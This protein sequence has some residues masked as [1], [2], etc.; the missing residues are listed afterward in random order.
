M[1]SMRLNAGVGGDGIAGFEAPT[2]ESNPSRRFVAWALVCT[3]GGAAG[4]ALCYW[5][6]GD[7]L[8]RSR[9]SGA[10]APRMTNLRS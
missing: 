5:I 7:H 3:L 8:M 6:R 1:A 4:V 2:T 10:Y 9:V